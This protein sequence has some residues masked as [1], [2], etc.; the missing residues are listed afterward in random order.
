MFRFIEW[1]SIENVLLFL[2]QHE[3]TLLE[4]HFKVPPSQSE[5]CGKRLTSWQGLTSTICFEMS[6]MELQIT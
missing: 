4:R 3:K 5:T 1:V 2:L 6:S